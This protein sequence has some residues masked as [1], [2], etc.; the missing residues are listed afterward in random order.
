MVSLMVNTVMDVI[1]TRLLVYFPNTTVYIFYIFNIIILF[2][3]TTIYLL[4]FSKPYPMAIL[5]G[6]CA[7]RIVLLFF[8]MIGKF[9]IG[10]TWEVPLWLQFMVLQD[11]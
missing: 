4:L 3:T 5:I 2:L 7:Y 8:F 1:N 9:G 11:L 10:F 6:R